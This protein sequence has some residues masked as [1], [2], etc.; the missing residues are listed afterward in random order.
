[1]YLIRKRQLGD[2]VWIEPIIK[3]LSKKYKRVVVFTKFNEIF[4]HNIYNNVF[5]KNNLSFFE[6]VLINFDKVFNSSFFSINLDNAYEYSPKQHLLH[7]YQKKAML[8]IENVYPEIKLSNEETE[9]IFFDGH[10]YA[11]I[12]NESFSI[13]NYRSIHGIDWSIVATYLCNNGFKVVQVGKENQRIKNTIYIKTDIRELICVVSKASLF[14]GIDSFP[15]H[16]AA[17]FKIPALIFF[18]AIN[19]NFRHFIDQFN[20]FFL[21]GYCEYAGCYHTATNLKEVTCKL[22][23]DE[24]IAKC[25]IY[26]SA[27]LLEHIKILTLKFNL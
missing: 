21:Q 9:R 11:I 18:G 5:Y 19:P 3:K 4:A 16:L 1:M 7:A 14:I 15:S 6:K 24:G 23:G 10:K 17:I 13:K 27:I 22:V 2:V 25:A 12:H 20:G 26:D 8:P